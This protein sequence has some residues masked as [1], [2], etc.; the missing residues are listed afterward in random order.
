MA[1]SSK[2][3]VFSPS[4]KMDSASMIRCLQALYKDHP[5]IEFDSISSDEKLQGFRVMF[6]EPEESTVLEKNQLLSEGEP[7]CI[8]P[9]TSFLIIFDVDQK[10][11]PLFERDVRDAIN[12]R[13]GKVLGIVKSN[14]SFQR[15]NWRIEIDIPEF[16]ELGV[17]HRNSATDMTISLPDRNEKLR[18]KR[19][20]RECQTCG[21][22]QH[23][24][25]GRSQD[26]DNTTERHEVSLNG[27]RKSIALP[28]RNSSVF[29]VVSRAEDSSRASS[30]SRSPVRDS[31][32]PSGVRPD[33]SIEPTERYAEKIGR[34][35]IMTSGLL[36][37]ENQKQ[38]E[39]E[40]ARFFKIAENDNLLS[41]KEIKKEKEDP[42]PSRDAKE[43]KTSESIKNEIPKSETVSSLKDELLALIRNVSMSNR[44]RDGNSDDDDVQ[45]IGDINENSPTKSPSRDFK[46]R[47]TVFILFYLFITT[48][49]FY[50]FRVAF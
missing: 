1:F 40:I 5:S 27:N 30:N 25:F 32:G 47:G 22:F 37:N 48:V 2:K 8:Y 14:G 38:K 44:S 6:S 23:E 41:N 46:K 42:E 9:L 31:E 36:S 34:E 4:E 29:R 12:K 18:V 45:V 19:W 24:C 39:S 16:K 35:E 13:F 7:V 10:K 20:C 33:F 15:N 3:G 26:E 11:T 43:L 21:H 17:F 28:K 49:P 50:D